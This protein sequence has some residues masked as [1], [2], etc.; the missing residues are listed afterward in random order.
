MT[1]EAIIPPYSNDSIPAIDPVDIG[2]VPDELLDDQWVNWVY[3][4]RDGKFTKVLHTPEGRPA[5]HSDPSTWSPWTE[6]F[7]NAEAEK[8]RTGVGRVLSADDAYFMVDLDDCYDPE[9]SLIEPWAQPW[10]KFAEAYGLYV[11]V[12][13]SGSGIKIIGKGTLP[14][15]GRREKIYDGDG[16]RV[17][18]IEL[19]DRLRFTTITGDIFKSVETV[20]EG[21]DLINSPY[22]GGRV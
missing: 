18:E 5:S 14:G 6:V 10:V 1:T 22:A 20:G 17:G 8:W 15:S 12:S 2:G 16:K 4:E 9:R 13:P 3:V 19:Y 7:D 11:E 21:Q